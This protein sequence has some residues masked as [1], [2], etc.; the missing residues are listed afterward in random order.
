MSPKVDATWSIQQLEK[1]YSMSEQATSLQ[2][3]K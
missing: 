3:M 1:P 2:R